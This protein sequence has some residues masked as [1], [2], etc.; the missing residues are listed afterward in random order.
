MF[1]F[2]AAVS[3]SPCE[4]LKLRK[5]TIVRWETCESAWEKW[6]QPRLHMPQSLRGRDYPAPI[7][8]T[9]NSRLADGSSNIPCCIVAVCNFIFKRLHRHHYFLEHFVLLLFWNTF[10]LVRAS[11]CRSKRLNLSSSVNNKS[12]RK[13]TYL[14]TFSQIFWPLNHEILSKLPTYAWMTLSHRCIL[15]KIQSFKY[16]IFAIGR[17]YSISFIFLC[18]YHELHRT[19]DPYLRTMVLLETMPDLAAGAHRVPFLVIIMHS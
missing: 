8:W 6:Q 17:V 12:S 11:V 2:E 15:H 9:M 10:H 5:I 19:E 3:H 1:C 13:R 4:F 7:V 16:Q 18:P 14:R